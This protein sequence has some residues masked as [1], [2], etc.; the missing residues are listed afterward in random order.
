MDAKTGGICGDNRFEVVE[1]ARKRLLL[2]T[3]IENSPKEMEV[4]DDI[5][6]RCWQMGWLDFDVREKLK[7]A[8]NRIRELEL[9]KMSDEY[10]RR[11]RMDD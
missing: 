3:N 5:L 6:Y 7:R 10:W 4:L 1:E 9:G 8:E 11:N 2:S